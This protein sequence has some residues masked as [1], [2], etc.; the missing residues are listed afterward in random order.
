ML[1]DRGGAQPEPVVLDFG[2]A[3]LLDAAERLTQT[4]SMMGTPTYMSPE[5]CRGATD[6]GPPADVYGLAIM[7][8]ELCVGQ[9]PFQARTVA[10]LAMKHVLEAPPP[11]AGAPP[12]LAQVIAACMAKEPASRPHAAAL[13][14][15]LRQAATSGAGLVGQASATPA[16]QPL[17][18][19]MAATMVSPTAGR[20]V[21]QAAQRAT[22]AA[23]QRSG[24]SWGITVLIVVTL[25]AIGGLVALFLRS[26][27]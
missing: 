14:Q 5:Q 23:Q 12:A 6:I 26:R 8:Y 21:D 3:K 25:V 13:A 11:L 7:T 9:P 27:V 20:D 16:P 10:E 18:S 17:D 22:A 1:D 24:W 15:A 4:G 2:L 19:H